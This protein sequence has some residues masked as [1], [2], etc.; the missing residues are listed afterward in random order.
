MNQKEINEIKE[1]MK[2]A[3]AISKEALE[4]IEKKQTYKR[5]DKVFLRDAGKL[6]EILYKKFPEYK[7]QSQEE[8][9]KQLQE[10]KQELLKELEKKEEP[11]AE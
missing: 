1:V 5:K 3:S 8:A 2:E 7:E 11:A 10:Y 6:R 4:F 9:K